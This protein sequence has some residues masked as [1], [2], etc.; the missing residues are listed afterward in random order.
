M[1]A[2]FLES[3]DTKAGHK[4]EVSD[5]KVA[6]KDVVARNGHDVA[7]FEATFTATRAEGA[8]VM[9][10]DM[11]SPLVLRVDDATEGEASYFGVITVSGEM[12]GAGSISST[13]KI[14][15]TK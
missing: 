5:V 1:R 9:R 13:A 12:T 10:M 14:V 8:N 6:F 15:R 2:R 3:L 7:E 11:R 4:P